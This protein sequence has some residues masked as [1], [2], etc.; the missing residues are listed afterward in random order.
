VQ[1]AAGALTGEGLAC[2]RGERLVFAGLSFR[3]A[4][5]GALL[6]RGSNGSGKTSLLRLIAGLGTP[7]AGRIAWDAAPIAADEAAHRARLHYVGERDAIKPALTPREMLGFWAALHGSDPSPP[8]GAALAAFALEAVAD[9]PCRW[10]SA[11]LR[12]RVALAR[13]VAAP[14]TLWLL[15]EPTT[16]LDAASQE[17]LEGTIRRHRAGGGRVVAATHAPI[18][19]DGAATIV[20]DDFAPPPGDPAFC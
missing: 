17:R 8:I 12:R 18:G 7:A 16:A 15:D 13:L 1:D 2:R 4:A 11:G 20:L 10:L 14:A 9:W 6:L 5:G 3:L 19:L